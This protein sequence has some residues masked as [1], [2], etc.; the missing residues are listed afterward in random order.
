MSRS[1]RSGRYVLLSS[2]RRATRDDVAVAV[3]RLAPAAQAV[4]GMSLGGLTTIALA[5]EAPE[6]VRKVVLVDVLP[7]L[8]GARSQH[9]VDFVNGP[10]PSPASTNCWTDR[11]VQPDPA[12]LVVAPRHPAQRRTAGGRNVGVAM[13]PSPT[14]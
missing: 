1:A 4:I 6:L 10:P 9:I 13:G 12:P 5:D 2:V 8:K 11:A 3:A 14:P 7:G